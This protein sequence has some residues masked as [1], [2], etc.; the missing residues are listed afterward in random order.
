MMKYA[1]GLLL[2]TTALA[3]AWEPLET[4]GEPKQVFSVYDPFFG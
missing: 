1:L 4:K 2:L 3:S